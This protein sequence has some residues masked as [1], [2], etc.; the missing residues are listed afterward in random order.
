MTN[1]L[2]EGYE[3]NV[4]WLFEALKDYIMP[5]HRVAVIAL[6]FRDSRVKNLDDW[7]AL[8]AKN[9]GCYYSGIVGSLA[10]YG[11]PE[12]QIEFINYYTDTPKTAAA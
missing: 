4:P 3:I 6:A 7:S 2:L 8:Y 12:S 5:S 11:I 9:S 1:I 10:D